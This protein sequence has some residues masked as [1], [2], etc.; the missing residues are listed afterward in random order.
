MLGKQD[1]V[2]AEQSEPL[3]LP[4]PLDVGRGGP[5]SLEHSERTGFIPLEE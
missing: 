5:P 1:D 3:L 2:R 4:L